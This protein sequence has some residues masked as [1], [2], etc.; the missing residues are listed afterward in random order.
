MD[1]AAL[2]AFVGVVVCFVLTIILY[3]KD[4][5]WKITMIGMGVCFVLVVVSSLLFYRGLGDSETVDGEP[6]PSS[7]E[8]QDAG[9]SEPGET[10]EPEESTNP[11][12]TP[13]ESE[14]PVES[15]PGSSKTEYAIGDTWTVDGQWEFTITDATE[16]QER[17]QYSDKTPGAV[18]IVDY[19]YKNLGYEKDG[20][21]GVYFSI[22]ETVVDSAG[23]MGGS[24]PGNIAKY[25]KET[26]VGAICDA[27]ACIGVENPGDFRL[28][29]SKYDGNDNR[30]S[31]TF[32]VSVE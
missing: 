11:V 25:A 12:E 20:F 28:T 15:N 2:A 26:P 9:E 32:V 5:P 7:T 3:M 19:S 14:P 22:D 6:D 24:Y 1:I 29:I 4:G 23:K 21:D 10:D 31:A 16:T 17:N 30:Q 27:Q 8:S 13:S 18:Y